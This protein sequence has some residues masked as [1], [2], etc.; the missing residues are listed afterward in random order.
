MIIVDGIESAVVGWTNIGDYKVV[1]YSVD[2]LS[3]LIDDD[4]EGAVSVSDIEEIVAHLEDQVT[5]QAQDMNLP[6]PVFVRTGD[7]EDI[8]R[9]FIGG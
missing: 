8:E 6:P 4:M 9:E 7:W 3:N 2:R 1:V 5:D